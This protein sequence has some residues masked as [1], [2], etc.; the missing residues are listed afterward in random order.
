MKKQKTEENKKQGFRIVTINDSK[1]IRE[2]YGHINLYHDCGY[3]GQKYYRY[4]QKH[5]KLPKKVENNYTEYGRELVKE[6]LE[7][8]GKTFV[9]KRI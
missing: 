9:K 2:L 7:E 1:Q 6:Y 4:Y 5:N 3:N 8:K